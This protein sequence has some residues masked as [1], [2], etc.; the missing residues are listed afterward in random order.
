MNTVRLSAIAALIFTPVAPIA[1]STP[2]HAKSPSQIQCEAE[3]GDFYRDRG[4]VYC[5]KETNV[6][7][8]PNSQTVTETESSNGTFNNKP[9]HRE[10][11][12]GPGNSRD[13]SNHCP[14]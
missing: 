3:G 8:S 14:D 4:Q 2:A 6:G 1:V 11:C 7:N 5:V 12:S 9:K 13:N 10:E